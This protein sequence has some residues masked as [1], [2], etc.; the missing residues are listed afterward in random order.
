[1]TIEAYG[2]EAVRAA[3][4]G[5]LAAGV[6]LMRHAAYALACACAGALR[7]RGV[8]HGRALVLVGGGN[9]GGDGLH[10]AA[11]LMNRGITT[12]VLLT[13]THVH[14]EGLARARETGVRVIDVTGDESCR[15]QWHSAAQR[16]H[17]WIDALAGIGVRGGLRGVAAHV[18]A[19]LNDL[20]RPHHTVLAVDAPSGIGADSGRV[21]GPVLAAD[22]TLTFGAA[23]AGLLLP[24]ATQ[25]VGRLE[26]V[27][28]GL[29]T[30][31][32]AHAPLVHRLETTDIAALWPV[33]GAADHKY[34][35]GVAGIVAGSVQYPGAGL[36]T[37]AAARAAGC[38]MVRYLGAEQVADRILSAYPDV[39]P[40]QGRVQ[41]LVIGP[42]IST[43]AEVDRL[44][45]HITA[46]AERARGGPLRLVWDAGALSLLPDQE[47]L[48]G[49]HPSVLTP[50]AGEL[51]TLLQA[52]GTRL[53][54]ADV[55]SEPAA[56]AAEAAQRTGAHVLLKG[57]V[58]IVA[59]PDGRCY[60][61]AEGT[62]W[63]A[64]AGSGDVLAG[65]LG[66]L[67]ATSGDD[68]GVLAAAAAS[69]HGRAGR[70]ASAGG[71]V[72]AQDIAAAIPAT[73]RAILAVSREW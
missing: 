54:R 22:R 60:S 70:R 39:V 3:E 5:P 50:H 35:R 42:G 23:K 20:R 34:T 12:T 58:T 61:Q 40:A 18:V 21:A 26:V 63:M 57:P 6:P 62:S 37:T 17:I 4:R 53:T 65:L 68:L 66:A 19:D 16:A 49:D 64:A 10:A 11:D 15:E 30:E 48:I 32:S 51:A 31:L 7:A 69:V 27:G 41:A 33:P 44:P 25:H 56:W 36:L 29:E 2:A 43:E 8:R 47:Q 45:G 59:S 28:L 55:E 38:G 71:P 14:S 73:V 52:Y 1:M 67:A 9:N 72:T 46:A 13:R 24:P